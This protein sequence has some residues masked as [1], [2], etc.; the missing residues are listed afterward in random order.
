MPF[1]N[2]GCGRPVLVQEDV[3]WEEGKWRQM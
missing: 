2:L 3:F 1:E